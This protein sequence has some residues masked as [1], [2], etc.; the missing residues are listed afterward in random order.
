[1]DG[2]AAAFEDPA[3][4][5]TVLS[6]LNR[7]LLITLVEWS[8]KPQTTIG[9]TRIASVEDALLFARRVR[10]LPRVAEQ[11]TCISRMLRYVADK[12]LPQV[13]AAASRTV[14]D[15]SGDGRENCNPEIPV[16]SVR[17]ELA[18]GDVTVNGLPILEGAE[19]D[20]LEEWYGSHVIGGRG[21]FLMPA[22]GFADF[23]RAMRQKF[24]IEISAAER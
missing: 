9:W 8:D 19:A 15:V 18:A 22:A 21:A 12:V 3:V 20:T 24:M 7:V 6:G 16:D 10:A 4:Q 11:F 14:V 5:H 17:D 2:I 1:M 23:A 13:P